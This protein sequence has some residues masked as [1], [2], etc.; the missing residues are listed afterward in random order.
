[1]NSKSHLHN[2]VRVPGCQMRPDS[3]VKNSAVLLERSSPGF[4]HDQPLL[5]REYQHE[6]KASKPNPVHPPREEDRA[7]P[8]YNKRWQLP[9]NYRKVISLNGP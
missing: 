3:S 6:V 5:A 9:G 8:R 7:S 2:E 4:W 1:M